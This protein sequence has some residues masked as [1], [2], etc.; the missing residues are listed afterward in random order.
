ML[1][2]LVSPPGMVETPRL[3]G[4]GKVSRSPRRGRERM[5]PRLKSTGLPLDCRVMDGQSRDCL[6]S[7]SNLFD[8]CLKATGLKPVVVCFS[9]KSRQERR[10][11][12]LT[13]GGLFDQALAKCPQELNWTTL[14]FDCP[15][16]WIEGEF[17]SI[18]RS[19]F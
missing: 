13:N 17:S 8:T 19:R 4:E 18:T 12:S 7:E 1:S 2:I 3:P 16:G 6:E 10:V 5:S 15:E 11:I 9:C 14:Q